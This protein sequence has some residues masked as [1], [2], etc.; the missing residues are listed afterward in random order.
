MIALLVLVHFAAICLIGLLGSFEM[1]GPAVG[2]WCMVAAAWLLAWL[3]VQRL[4]ALRLASPD[5]QRLVNLALPVLF[6][7]WLL[8]LWE[9]V[10]RGFGVPAI[11]LP[12]PSM[13]AARIAVV[14]ADAVG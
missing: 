4:A 9:I 5:A 13:I 2:Y 8:I 7:A 6:G 1:S 12:P 10:V 14:G 11:L 3:G